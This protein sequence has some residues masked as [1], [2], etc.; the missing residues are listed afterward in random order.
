MANKRSWD[1]QHQR[2]RLDYLFRAYVP[3]Q[4]HAW[5][6]RSGLL[7]ELAR[8]CGEHYRWGE[9]IHVGPTL[10]RQEWSIFGFKEYE[11]KLQFEAGLPAVLAIEIKPV[12]GVPLPNGFANP[13]RDFSDLARR[14]ARKTP[15]LR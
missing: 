4:G 7:D 14:M 15:N 2:N 12:E 5:H 13:D 9:T 10:D 3:R 11:R 1:L 8:Q 6:V